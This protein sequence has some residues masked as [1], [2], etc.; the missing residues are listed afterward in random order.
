MKLRLQISVC[1]LFL[2]NSIYAQDVKV[3]ARIDKPAYQIGDYIRLQ[4]QATLDSSTQLI[5][6]DA[7]QV[8]S[9]DIISVNPVDTIRQQSDF[10][11]NQE[12][13]YSIYDSGAYSIPAIR[14]EYKK[15]GEQISNAV[16][17]DSIQ[18]FVHTMAVDTT[19]AIKPI[20][21]NLDVVVRNYVW[22]YITAGVV[23]LIAIVL[24]LYFTF[25]RKK[26]IK[27]ILPKAKA[28][29]LHEIMLD[30]LRALD[31]KKLWQQ[32]RVK[33]YYI[34]LTDILRE[35]MEKRFSMNALE[36]TTDE[37]L[38][39]LSHLHI[40]R[41][42]TSQVEFILEVADMAKFAKSKPLP[43]ENTLAMNHA[44]NFIES[45]KPVETVT[46]EKK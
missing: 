16:F 28:K 43:N 2:L 10:V 34:E 20:K 13:V 30:K 45:T 23:A 7:N 46:T 33:E 14:F 25:F 42:L 1:L 15:A 37:I 36:S 41:T 9:F 19:T 3:A 24:I 6:P 32:E 17:T 35:Y 21:G 39:Q 38:S 31:Q 27:A 40:D 4:V 44:V 29:P 22:L 5:W 18:F 12:I 8:T 11:L 26:D